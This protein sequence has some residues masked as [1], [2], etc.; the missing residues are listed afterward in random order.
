LIPKQSTIQQQHKKISMCLPREESDSEMGEP[1]EQVPEPAEAPPEA[2]EEMP[3]QLEMILDEMYDLLTE[4]LEVLTDH[5]LHILQD[6]L[7]LEG[8]YVQLIVHPPPQVGGGAIFVGEMTAPN[9]PAPIQPEPNPILA[10]VED[11]IN[12]SSDEEEPG[13]EPIYISSD[14]GEDLEEL[15]E[16][17]P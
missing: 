9:P 15:M 14:E 10:F 3:F 7:G 12:I 13:P 5:Q 1:I 17:I 11:V 4:G 2:G 6:I 16:A 8:T